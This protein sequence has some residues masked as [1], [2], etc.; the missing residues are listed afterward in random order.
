MKPMMNGISGQE[1]RKHSP[2]SIA[3]LETAAQM[4]T[5]GAYPNAIGTPSDVDTTRSLHFR[6]QVSSFS[7][8]KTCLCIIGSYNY[9][10][11]PEVADAFEKHLPTSRIT[12]GKEAHRNGIVVEVGRES[13]PVLYLHRRASSLGDDDPF[14]T[15]EDFKKQAEAFAKDAGADEQSMIEESGSTSTGRS[16]FRV[17]WD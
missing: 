5:A 9:F 1:I 10:D 12:G 16:T 4:A 8:L 11:G 7:D 15:E 14:L 6:A 17:W 2:S 13:S 3:D